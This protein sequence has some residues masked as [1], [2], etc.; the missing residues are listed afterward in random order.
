MTTSEALEAVSK[1]YIPGAVDFYGKIPGDPWMEAHEALEKAVRTGAD[2]TK[3]LA[4]QQ[5]VSR[6]KELLEAYS[7]M[8]PAPKQLTMNDGMAIGNVNRL[9]MHDSKRNKCCMHCESQSNLTVHNDVNETMVY[10]VCRDCLKSR[11][12]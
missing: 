4:A 1:A 7:R 6:T 2:S 10:I 9:M 5:F 12:A 3:R 8:R 11:S